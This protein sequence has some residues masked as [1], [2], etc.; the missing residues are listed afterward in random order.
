M[1][2]RF[3]YRTEAIEIDGVDTLAAHQRT[4]RVLRI[5]STF[6]RGAVSASFP[7]A[8][9]AIKDVLGSETWAG[10][11]TAASTAGSALAAGWLAAFM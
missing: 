1:R 5:S 6:S 9:L 11:S 3:G 4:L 8:V 10:L 2:R 7:V